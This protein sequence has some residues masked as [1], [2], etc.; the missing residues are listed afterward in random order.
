ME[1]LS[2][3]LGSISNVTCCCSPPRGAL[4]ARTRCRQRG[5]PRDPVAL[6]LELLLVL[7]VVL[8]VFGG[9]LAFIGVVLMG[10]LLHCLSRG[11]EIATLAWEFFQFKQ[12]AA[13]DV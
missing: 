10:F 1:V 12:G 5:L 4:L 13:V 2:V 9:L 3:V 6:L 11:S 7:V 8:T